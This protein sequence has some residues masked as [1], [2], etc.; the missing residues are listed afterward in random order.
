[1]IHITKDEEP[2]FWKEF[3]RKNPNLSYHQLQDTEE[4]RA[5]R[6][7]LREHLLNQQHYICCYCCRGIDMENSL[8][9]HIRPKD[10]YPNETMN[11]EN[12]LASCEKDKKTCGPKKDNEYDERMFVSPLDEN[13][14][15]QFAFF[16]NGDIVGTTE[17][18]EYTAKVLGLDSYK[19]QQA[20][21]AIYK[22]CSDMDQDSLQWYLE[23][24]DGR[25]QPFIDVIRYYAKNEL[26]Q[27]EK[28]N[29][30]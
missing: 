15:E 8:N 30:K 6:Q 26:K 12:I 7:R 4:G 27:G 11:Y 18:G 20:R 21:K 9:E 13:C 16:P 24:H 10:S 2:E 1:M 22:N 3:K 23:E 14:E 29:G 17:K 28:Q 25:L 5:I 19:L